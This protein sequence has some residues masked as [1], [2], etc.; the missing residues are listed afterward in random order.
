MPDPTIPRVLPGDSGDAS[1]SKLA[2]MLATVFQEVASWDWVAL[3][4]LALAVAT[5]ALAWQNR[6]VVSTS[7]RQLETAQQDLALAREQNV[8]IKDQAATAQ[9]ALETQTAPFLT[10]VPPGL[11]QEPYVWGGSGDPVM[12]R[13]AATVEAAT[14]SGQHRPEAHISVPFRNVGAGVATL[15]N[16]IF[17]FGGGTPLVGQTVNPV[18]PSGER[19]RARFDVDPDSSS[20]WD[21]VV[22]GVS[23]GTFSVIVE[24]AD[25]SGRVRGAVRLDAHRAA[26]GNEKWFIRQVHFADDWE[27]AREHPRSSSQPLA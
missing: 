12:F 7:Q 14:V 4:T 26:S 1:L 13:D 16:V 5:F 2:L 27:Q 17:L 20:G 22:G 9:A 11:D 10:N 15:T 24:H 6:R 8:A 25:S 21:E 23:A 3:G 18:L 19:T